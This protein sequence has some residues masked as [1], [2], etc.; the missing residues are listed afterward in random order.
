MKLIDIILFSLCVG[1]FIIGVHQTMVVGVFKAYWLFM[2]SVSL[3]LIYSARKRKIDE[4]QEKENVGEK[5]KAS[6]QKNRK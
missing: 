4:K 6:K 1:F 2:L 3:L 5:A